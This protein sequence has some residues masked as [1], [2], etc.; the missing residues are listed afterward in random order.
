[1]TRLYGHS[2]ATGAKL[3]T[4][5]EDPITIFEAQL[6]QAGIVSPKE[7]NEIR[8]R[9][10]AE[11]LDMA[12]RVKEEPMPDPSTIYDHTFFGQKGRYF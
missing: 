5:E 4:S 1:V 12:K 7:A 8:E 3:I 10:N 6:A 11:M 9:Y 2:S